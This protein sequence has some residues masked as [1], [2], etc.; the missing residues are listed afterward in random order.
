LAGEVSSAEEPTAKDKGKMKSREVRKMQEA[1]PALEDFVKLKNYRWWRESWV[2]GKSWRN[3]IIDRYAFVQKWVMLICLPT[4]DS[5][6][7]V[8][9]RQ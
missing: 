1:I 6:I 3:R 2:F 5:P 9:G 7:L 4:L 8:D